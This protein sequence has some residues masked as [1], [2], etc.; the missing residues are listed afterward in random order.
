MVR[1]ADRYSDTARPGL[2]GPARGSGVAVSS[3]ATETGDGA[4]EQSLAYDMIEVHGADAAVV[5]RDNAR[6]A[7]LAGQGRRQNP[8][9][10]CLGS[11]SDVGPTR[12][13]VQRSL[14]A[15]PCSYRP[16]AQPKDNKKCIFHSRTAER[17][18]SKNG[19]TTIVSRTTMTISPAEPRPLLSRSRRPIAKRWRSRR[20]VRGVYPE[21]ADRSDRTGDFA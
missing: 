3:T 20:I 1:P 2:G 15:G 16:P 10:E 7:A 4:E 6:T 8:G 21:L 9:S 18:A 5:A 14:T 13:R 19:P 11:F 12:I 17:L